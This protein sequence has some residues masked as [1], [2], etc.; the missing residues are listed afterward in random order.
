MSGIIIPTI[1]SDLNAKTKSIKDHE[2]LMCGSGKAELIVNTFRHAVNLEEKTRSCRPWQVTRKPYSHALAFIAKIS[3][4]VQ[5]DDFVHE[6]FSVDRFRKTY[7]SKFK[8]N[9]LILM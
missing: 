5:M 7:A 8:I 1:I 3:S 6:Y 4:E 2:V 9:V